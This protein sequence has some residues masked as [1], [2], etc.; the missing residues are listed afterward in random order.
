M[1]GLAGIARDYA[2][3]LIDATGGNGKTKK[4]LKDGDALREDLQYQAATG[5]YK[6]IVTELQ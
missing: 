2:T 3:D 6:D 4:L 5:K 1:D